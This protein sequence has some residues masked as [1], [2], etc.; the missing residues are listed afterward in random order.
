MMRLLHNSVFIVPRDY[1]TLAPRAGKVSAHPEQGRRVEWIPGGG[2][3]DRQVTQR[4]LDG[5]KMLKVCLWRA[6]RRDVCV[7]VI[8][9]LREES[10]AG[11]S[12]LDNMSRISNMFQHKELR[13]GLLM[14]VG[15]A[16][17]DPSEQVTVIQESHHHLHKL[18]TP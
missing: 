14:E 4:S 13:K 1:F 3:D 10:R 12:V 7:T 6:P 9:R 5:S 2:P 17:T 15:R 8:P 18:E 11:D 16:S